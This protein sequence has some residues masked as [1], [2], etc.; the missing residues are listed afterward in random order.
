MARTRTFLAVDIG[1]AIRKRVAAVQ[2]ELAATGA[3]VKWVEPASYHVTLHFLG[4]LDDRDLAQVCRATMKETAKIESFRMSIAG[5]G[6]FPNER[7]PKI[8][9]AGI[10]EGTENLVSLFT[11]IEA[12]LADLGIYRKE[13]RPYTPHLT[14][15]RAA[16]EADGEL[17]APELEKHRGWTGGITTVDEVLVLASDL[18]RSG[19]EYTVMGRAPLK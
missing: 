13:D 5:L 7:R 18:K 6:A 9:W 3:I 11:A 17:I 19:P 15:G 14:L 10:D 12:P 2:A 8:L 1:D 4:E 16:T